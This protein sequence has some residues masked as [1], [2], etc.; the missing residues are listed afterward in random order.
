MSSIL[1]KTPLTLALE[2]IGFQTDNFGQDLEMQFTLMSTKILDKVYSGKKDILESVELTTI[3]AL[4]KKRLKM[5]VTFI[6]NSM[7][8]AIMP[9][10]SNKNHIFLNEIWRGNFSIPGQDRLIKDSKDKEGWVNTDKATLGGV[11]S[12]YVNTVYLNIEYLFGPAKMSP[13]EVTAIL[14]HELG[15]GFGACEYA[16]RS[17][18]TNQIL[19]SVAKELSLGSEKADKE[20]IFRE[21]T[22]VNA[23]TTKEAVEDLVNGNRVVAG[24]RWFETVLGSVG[25]GMENKKY[26]ETSFE[27][28]ADNFAS[29]FNYGR[30]LITGLDKLYK[31]S[32]S[33]ERSKS[34]YV[35]TYTV[36]VAMEM[37]R[38]F[39]LAYGLVTFAVPLVVL[40][41]VS[42]ALS[43]FSSGE[44]NRDFT[45]D[46]LK[47]RYKRIR[48][49]MVELLK[50]DTL[51]KDIIKSTLDNIKF[52]DSIITETYKYRGLMDQFMN[53]F[54]PSARKAD[55][56]I[57][58]QQLMEDLS[59]NELFV[60]SGELKV[61]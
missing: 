14:L 45:Y 55:Q 34:I 54:V 20:Y 51:S 22:L 9:F 52:F 25:S 35:F 41:S 27:S 44:E 12:L 49:D 42:L 17:A 31:D 1:S 6:V 39:L 36:G 43:W 11:F 23:S 19:A 26:D 4:I 28:L 46:D 33:P 24:T 59:F 16:D 18:T 15:H 53:T 37:L 5:S 48:N 57:A 47:I 40:M 32:G 2:S 7:M 58:R 50:S 3:V 56:A 10:Y 21:L 38:G 61:L 29:R 13:A 8:A 30:P 60:K